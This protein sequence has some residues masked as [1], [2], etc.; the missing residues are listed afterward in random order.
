MQTPIFIVNC[1]RIPRRQWYYLR[2]PINDQVIQRIKNLPDDSRKWNAGMMCWEINVS[3]LFALIKRYR[4]STKIHFDFGSE[5]SRKIFID[6][7]RKVEVTEREK[8]KFIAELNIKKE[9]W[10]KYKEELETSYKEHSEKMHSFLKEGIVLYPHQIIAAMFMNVTRNTL[11]SHEM[12]LGKAEPL[13]S[14]LVTPNG[15]VRMGDIKVGDYVIGSDGKPKKVLGVYP[16]GLKDIHEIKFND[17]TTARS[18]DEHLWNVNTYIR[19]W[20]GNP[21]MTKTLREIIDGGLQFKNGNNKWYIPIVKPIEFSE[22]ELKIDPYILGCLLG[23]GNITTRSSIGFSSIDNEIIN[24]ISIRLPKN[25]EIIQKKNSDKDYYI[26]GNK[27]VNKIF[28]F[29]FFV[30]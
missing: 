2:F 21:F 7:I 18:C 1:E 27:N 20:R 8:R 30:I 9:E 19:N 28:S 29:K 26:R 12:G 11:I 15:L 10:V 22:K 3:S 6:R 13:D 5:E 23:D 24:E 16:Q 17:G 4:G 14:K 25:H